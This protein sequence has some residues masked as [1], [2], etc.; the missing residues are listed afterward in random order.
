MKRLVT[1]GCSN[2]QGQ[3]LENPKEEVW[4]AVLARHLGREFVNKGK[5]GASNKYIAYSIEQFNFLPN[6][7]AIISWSFLDRYS[8][9][10]D[11]KDFEG[12]EFIKDVHPRFA[13]EDETSGVYYHLFHNDYDS[14]FINK[15]F[16]DYSIDLLLY[17]Q[18]EFKQIYFDR[19][20][21]INSRH[22]K[23]NTFSFFYSAF[24]INYPKGIDNSHMGFEGHRALGDAMYKVYE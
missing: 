18:I 15:V 7:L 21:F 4:G 9:I 23:T 14:K 11:P 10:K 22:N 16:I 17:K 13:R 8:I 19:E 3:G 20:E 2:T 5:Q 1:F 6:D 12:Y 24:Y